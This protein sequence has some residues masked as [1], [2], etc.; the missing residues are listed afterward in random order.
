MS[1]RSQKAVELFLSGYNCCQAVVGAFVDVINIDFNT[2]VK[3]ASGFGGGVGRMREICGAVS[4]M[5]FVLSNVDGYSEPGD[6]EKKKELYAK[7]QKLSAIFKERE[8]SIVC[9]ELL[10]KKITDDKSS[11]PSPRTAEYYHSRG[12]VGCVEC[13]SQILDDYLSGKLQ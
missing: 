2:A 9:R 5:V 8:G 11:V 6:T 13:A 12:C 3:I 10:P 1:E 4:G 7:I